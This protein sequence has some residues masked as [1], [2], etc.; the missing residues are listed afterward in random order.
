MSHAYRPTFDGLSQPGS[1]ASRW[2]RDIKGGML[3]QDIRGC[4]GDLRPES[5]H[6]PSVEVT[7]IRRDMH[8][9]H[10]FEEATVTEW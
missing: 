2:S 8:M 3:H 6:S 9:L 7:L 10:P 4:L 5:Q 1:S